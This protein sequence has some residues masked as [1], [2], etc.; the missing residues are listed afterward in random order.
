MKINSEVIWEQAEVLASSINDAYRN[1]LNPDIRFCGE[2]I[3]HAVEDISANYGKRR[4]LVICSVV[5]NYM[6]YRS[7]R[8]VRAVAMVN[9]LPLEQDSDDK[10]VTFEMFITC[11]K[12]HLAFYKRDWK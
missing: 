1:R 2:T 6:P 7:D 9:A 5:A 12:F 8:F 4:F 10:D 3:A 11:L